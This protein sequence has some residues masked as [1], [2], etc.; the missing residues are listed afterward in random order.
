MLSGTPSAL[1]VAPPERGEQSDEILAEFGFGAD[2]I[3]DLRRN[4][5]VYTQSA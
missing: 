4:G 2:E 1:R 3:A 5:T